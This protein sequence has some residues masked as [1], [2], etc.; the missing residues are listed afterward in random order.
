MIISFGTSGQVASELGR[1]DGVKT[2]G[3]DVADFRSPAACADFVLSS[4]ARAII[5]AVAYTDVENAEHEEGTANLINGFTPG[6]IARACV[7]L[8]IPIIHIS[9]D[10]VFDGCASV[11]YG[12]D[13]ICAPINAYGRSKLLGETL[14]INSGARHA[15]LRT[16]WVFSE[17]SNSF[18]SKVL[19]K[20]KSHNFIDVVDDQVGGPTPAASIAGA[21]VQI[22]YALMESDTKSGVYHLSGLPD[23]SWADFAIEIFELANAPAAIRPVLSNILSGKAPRPKN[24]RLDCTSTLKVFGVKRPNWKSELLELVTKI[25]EE[26]D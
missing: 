25:K 26:N 14:I 22:A 3:R 10:Y 1:F 20:A 5:N 21:C 19:Q 8:N 18:P 9:S 16:S 13:A 4:G 12:P 23:T 11:P 17:K 15:I 6:E 24:S 2:V 7:K